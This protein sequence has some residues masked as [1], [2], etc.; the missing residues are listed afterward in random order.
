MASRE[1]PSCWYAHADGTSAVD[2]AIVGSE[3]EVD[4][5][6]ALSKLAPSEPQPAPPLHIAGGAVVIKLQ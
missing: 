5:L 1:G 6:D 2:D 3:F 4:D